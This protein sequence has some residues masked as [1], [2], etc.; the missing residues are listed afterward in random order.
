MT[1]LSKDYTVVKRSEELEKDFLFSPSVLKL[2]SGRILVSLDINGRYGEIYASDDGGITWLLKGTGN[3]CHARL[4]TDGDVIYLIGHKGKLIIYRSFDGGEHWSDE[5][6]I[7]EGAWHQSACSVWYKNEYIYLVMEQLVRDTSFPYWCPN[8][9]APVVM[10]GKLG[11][12]LTKKEN[13][14]FSERVTF[15]ELVP[16]EDVL[17]YFGVPFFTSALKCP[18][19]ATHTLSTADYKKAFNF[20]SNKEGKAF[21][22]QPIGWLETNV[23]EITD[24]N[25]YWYD[26]LEKTLLLFM[27]AHT[28]GS[29][30]CCVAKAVE[31]TVDGK[32]EIKIEPLT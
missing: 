30:Y 18:P 24:K 8:I 22:T 11:T 27:R 17:E 19:D 32:D 9:L 15:K 13:W 4:F 5:Y 7:S 31:Q 25:H 10:R 23:V 3:F 12:D 1:A 29:G 2:K 26:P 21:S 16:N 28:A 6:V 14:L 20:E